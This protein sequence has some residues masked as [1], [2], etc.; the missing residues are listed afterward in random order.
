MT[1]ESVKIIEKKSFDTLKSEFNYT[2]MLQSPRLTKI[3]VSVATGTAM[4]K[5]KNRND[6]VVDRLSKITGQKPTIRLA[7]KAVASFKTR[8]GDKIAESINLENCNPIFAPVTATNPSTQ[9]PPIVT[10]PPVTQTPIPVSKV[11][12][13]GDVTL[14][15]GQ[16]AEFK[17]ISIKIISIEEDS[18]CPSDVQCIQAGTV[19]VKAEVKSGMG[20]SVSILKLGQ[21]FTTEGEV[22]TLTSVTPNKKSQVI[23]S[24]KDYRFVV[25]VVPQ[26]TAIK[27]GQGSG[28]YVGG[29]SAQLCTDRPD[30]V[31]TCEY[32]EKYA[33]YKTAT[34]ERQVSGECGWTRSIELNSCLAN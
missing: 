16:L 3:V 20:T 7:K 21:V 22:I 24:P 12:P 15:L 10:D 23:V 28:C 11:L 13:Y 30:A 29:C 33:C 6:L 8:Q 34:C 2:N 14:K 19:R 17:N 9:T 31:S 5:D 32:N 27:P 25:N 18:R 1:K 4:K 26:G